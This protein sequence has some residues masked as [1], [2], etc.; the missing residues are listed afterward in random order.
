MGPIAGGIGRDPQ[1]VKSVLDVQ[2]A[3]LWEK[4][5]ELQTAREASRAVRLRGTVHLDLKALNRG[6]IIATVGGILLGVSVFLP[7][8]S[9]G[10]SHAV[11]N[12]CTGPNTT[13]SGW[14]SL[15]AFRYLILLAAIAP[16][17]LAWVIARGHALAWPRGELTAVVA[18]VALVMVLFRG[19]IVAP[20]SPPEEISVSWGFWVALLGSLLILAGAVWRSQESAPRRKPPGVL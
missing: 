12:S 17:I 7:W 3:G 11:L 9:L 5:A 18:V 16:L 20:G 1:R 2:H 8:F 6:E 14:D 15:S 13:C 19:V 4:L 10:N